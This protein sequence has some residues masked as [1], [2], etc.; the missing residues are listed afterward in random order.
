M[1]YWVPQDLD[2]VSRLPPFFRADVR[3]SKLWAF[4]DWTLEA[5]LDVMNVS[6]S[7]EVVGYEYGVEGNVLQRAQIDIPVVL[8]MLGLKGRY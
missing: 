5:Y 6:L 2:R 7:R 1:R 3:V 8:P 4:D